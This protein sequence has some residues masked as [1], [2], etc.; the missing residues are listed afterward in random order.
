M[1]IIALCVA[2]F[3]ADRK[4]GRKTRGERSG[5][6]LVDILIRL[7]EPPAFGVSEYHILC[8]YAPQHV[9][10]IFSRERASL[11]IKHI[12]RAEADA[13]AAVREREVGEKR[14]RR[15]HDKRPAE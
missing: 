7:A 3:L 6:F 2:S 10:R 9:G 13:R 8:F 11:L 1:E 5:N 14:C 15:A 12:L 4:D